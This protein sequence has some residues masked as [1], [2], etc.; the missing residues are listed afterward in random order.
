MPLLFLFIALVTMFSYAFMLSPIFFLLAIASAVYYSKKRKHIFAS[1][2]T[3]IVS[4]FILISM[5]LLTLIV[6]FG[7]G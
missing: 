7:Q 6:T 3:F 2:V 1:V 5:G 4:L